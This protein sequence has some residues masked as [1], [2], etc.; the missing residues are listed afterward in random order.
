MDASPASLDINSLGVGGPASP[1]RRT[2]AGGGGGQSDTPPVMP[3]TERSSGATPPVHPDSVASLGASTAARAP[4]PRTAAAAA[5]LLSPLPPPILWLSSAAAARTSLARVSLWSSAS[6]CTACPERSASSSS[7]I[8]RRTS[9]T[10]CLVPSATSGPP[11]P[12]PGRGPPSPALVR[13]LTDSGLGGDAL[14]AAGATPGPLTPLAASDTA[15][16]AAMRCWVPHAASSPAS[17]Q[18]GPG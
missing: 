16:A 10:A 3:E 13:C 5:P 6:R 12:S 14:V 17:S 4:G 15:G 9:S 2:S 11:R 8:S 1:P 18:N 7:A